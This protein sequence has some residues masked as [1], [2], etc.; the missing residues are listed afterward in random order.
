MSGTVVGAR[1]APPGQGK[2]PCPPSGCCGGVQGAAR[3]GATPSPPLGA[4]G[5]LPHTGHRSRG[6]P[7][8]HPC[9]SPLWPVSPTARG[10]GGGPPPQP[11]HP[12]P[13]HPA[14]AGPTDSQDRPRLPGKGEILYFCPEEGGELVPGASRHRARG[15]T[16][17]GDGR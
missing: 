4:P 5:G 17:G 10:G 3:P 11:Q 6:G 12:L 8:A 7:T 1:T 13:S 15:A 9:L 2:R 16:A 14:A